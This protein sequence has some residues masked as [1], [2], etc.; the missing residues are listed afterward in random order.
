MK[1]QTL[2]SALTTGVIMLGAVTTISSPSKA[3]DQTYFCEESGGVWTTFVRNYDNKKIPLVRWETNLAEDTP[4]I[5][6][7]EV[8]NKFQKAYTTGALN[9]MTTGTMGGQHVV[10]G[11]N[12]YGNP[13]KEVLFALKSHQD[14]NYILQNLKNQGYGLNE[15]IKQSHSSIYIDMNLLLN[16][17]PME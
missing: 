13:C 16:G 7:Q 8:S 5:R 15:P 11:T 14:A 12:Q 17:K 10:C 6:C 9:F 2:M 1:H 4:H 3:Q